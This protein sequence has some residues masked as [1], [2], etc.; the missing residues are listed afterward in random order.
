MDRKFIASLLFVLVLILPHVPEALAQLPVQ[1][2]PIPEL[3]VFDDIML[4]Y[5]DFC[6]IY[7]GVLGIMKDDRIVYLRS[8][9]YRNQGNS[10]ILPEN[11]LM[12]IAS[13]NKPFTA[14]VIHDLERRDLLRLDQRVFTLDP[15]ED[16][17]LDYEPFGGNLGDPR[18]ADITVIHLLRHRGGWDREVAGDLT[19]MEVTIAL[20]MGLSPYRPPTRRET[21]EWI[22]AYPLQHDPG[23]EDQE[24]YSNIGYLILGLIAEQVSGTSLHNYWRQHILT[25]ELWFPASEYEPGRTF[26]VDQNPREPWYNSTTTA[27]NVYDPYGPHVMR[28][29]G[30][31]NHEAR[32]GQGGLISSAVPLLH[33]ANNYFCSGDSI[34]VPLNGRSEWRAHSG[35]NYG[36]GALA[37]QR[38]DGINFAIIINKKAPGDVTYMSELMVLIDDQINAGGFTWPTEPVD[39]VWFEFGHGGTEFG[40]YDLPFDNMDDFINVMP[41]TKVRFKP[42][43]QEWSG[44]ISTGKVIMDAPEG[45]AIIG[46]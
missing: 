7:T 28:P 32:I 1:G 21:V 24:H 6:S 11:A 8:F 27:Q 14:A 18:L 26:A 39:G 35:S 41:Y 46:Q 31:W 29:Y 42:G 25:G 30:G 4:D 2:K 45:T 44:V 12:R 43:S 10:W 36:T 5:M 15:E 40:S 19:Y 23:D 34:G 20:V 9:G 3:A 38:G 13:V 37:R 16:G 17:I 33:L 22:M